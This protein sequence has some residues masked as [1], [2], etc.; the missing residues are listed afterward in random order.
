MTNIFKPIGNFFRE[1]VKHMKLGAGIILAIF[2]LGLLFMITTAPRE[3]EGFNLKPQCPNILVQ[4]GKQIILYNSKLAKI[5]GVNPVVFNDLEGY[6]EYVTWQ[7]SQG[8]NCPILFLQHSYDAQGNSVYKNRPSPTDPQ[9]GLPLISGLNISGNSTNRSKLLDAG[10]NNPPYNQNMYPSYDGEDQYVGLI[11]PLDKIFHQDK[12]GV[13][14]SAMDANWGG[15]KYTQSLI[16]K[17]DYEEDN[18]KIY[19]PS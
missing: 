9:G 15:G 17:G 3:R 12:N 16:D 18:V 8:I 2:I 6:V 10:R 19:V 5:P 13:S 11:T 4:K 1:N 14:P 7:R